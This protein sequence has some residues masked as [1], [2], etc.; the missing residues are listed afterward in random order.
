[1]VWVVKL[2]IFLG[3]TQHFH[4]GETPRRPGLHFPQQ[5]AP[6]VAAFADQVL[7]ALAL[8][9]EIFFADDR[10]WC[11]YVPANVE[12]KSPNEKQLYW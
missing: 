6:G 7:E 11:R 8:H 4:G 3:E 5:L 1:M 2:T 12:Q 9:L 10:G